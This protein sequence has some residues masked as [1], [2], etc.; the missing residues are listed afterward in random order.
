MAA[1]EEACPSVRLSGSKSL[2]LRN[3]DSK[4][5]RGRMKKK[6]VVSDGDKRRRGK[7]EREKGTS[8]KK[9]SQFRDSSSS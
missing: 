7:G 1:I 6:E 3:R 4:G 5:K 8:G 2:C 9:E